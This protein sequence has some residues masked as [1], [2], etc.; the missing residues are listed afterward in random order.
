MAW[1]GEERRAGKERR[2]LERRRTTQ[3]HVRTLVII[4]GVT[5]IVTDGA[6]RRLYIRRREDREE[7]AHRVADILRP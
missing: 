1:N 4:E 7:L 5:W 2:L 6:D 3:Y